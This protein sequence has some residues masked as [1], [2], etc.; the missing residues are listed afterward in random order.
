MLKSGA[1]CTGSALLEDL[2]IRVFPL[3]SGSVFLMLIYKPPSASFLL[4]LPLELED[5]VA[6]E[7]F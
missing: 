5:A 3:T 7:T 6:L 1:F 2:K 4:A